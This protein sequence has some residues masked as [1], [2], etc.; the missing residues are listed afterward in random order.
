METIISCSSGSDKNVAIS[1]IRVSG[2]K[3]ITNFQKYIK[4]DLSRIEP[5]KSYFSSIK[6]NE[7]ELLDEIVLTFFKGPLSYNGENILELSVHG[8]KLN[9]K[10]I[11][12]LF[13]DNNLARLA[14]NGEFT[15]RALKNKKLNLSQIEGLGQL[16][17][18]TTEYDLRQGLS[19]LNGSLSRDY[20]L[21]Y[22]SLKDLMIKLELM[23]DFSD[24]V[25]LEEIRESI[26]KSS[27]VFGETF[28]KLLNRAKLGRKRYLTL[29]ICIYGEPN[30]GKSTLFNSILGLD[31]A[32]VSKEAG[33]TRDY[34]SEIL[35]F[36][37]NEFRLIDTAG[38]RETPNEIEK[39]GIEK[40]NLLLRDSF[41]KI[42]VISN[43]SQAQIQTKRNNFDLVVVTHCEGNLNEMTN[44]L[45]EISEY[46]APFLFLGKGEDFHSVKGYLG[47]NKSWFN[48]EKEVLK[49]DGSIGPKE[50]G[51]IGP[52]MDY[53]NNNYFDTVG[54]FV[55]NIAHAKL[56]ER[57]SG[58]PL[59]VTRHIDSIVACEILW[60]RLNDVLN[61]NEFDLGL[62]LCV[63]EDFSSE[64][65][66]LLG[67]IPAEELLD[68]I[69]SNF[70]I[71]K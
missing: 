41:Y 40:S 57:L 25:G 35:L 42:L 26:N 65:E 8:N 9:V 34:I 22:N 14:E 44:N 63:C 5:R 6:N 51:S 52:S 31:R 32:I 37:N 17:N 11:I 39:K 46:G 55:M 21:L 16:L 38:V 1:L 68:D 50:S 64:L 27:K 59:T 45:S 62:A 23:M 36:K 4:I 29:D 2:F 10:N 53:V 30:V 24:D 71:G 49:A 43:V 18:S 60:V 66:S 67:I 70:C 47:I 69:F 12:D 54:C 58:K 20:Q 61:A 7:G 56:S 15:L 28:L 3:N 19:L 48:Y 13:I 33:T